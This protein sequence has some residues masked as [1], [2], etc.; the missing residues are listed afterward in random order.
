MD[1]RDGLVN[2]QRLRL[3]GR[4]AQ[5]DTGPMELPRDDLS[6]FDFRQVRQ[7]HR[8]AGDDGQPM[9]GTED[10]VDGTADGLA[11]NLLSAQV[12]QDP[13]AVLHAASE[14][15]G[16]VQSRVRRAESQGR[17]CLLLPSPQADKDARLRRHV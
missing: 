13:H 7:E 2:R 12:R 1:A 8:L 4:S 16:H 11:K 5:P 6:G 10:A 17:P 9:E 15:V 14:A 3:Q